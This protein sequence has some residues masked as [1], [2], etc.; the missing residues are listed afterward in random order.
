MFNPSRDQVRDL[1]FETW[2]KYRA[3]EPLAGVESLALAATL[4]HPEYH[5]ML[6]APERSRARDYLP[7]LGESNPFL[8]L[9]L[10]LAL[11]E[12]LSIDQPRGVAAAFARLL[13]RWLANQAARS[14][15]SC[16]ESGSAKP[17]MIALL[18]RPAL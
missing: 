2:R 6:D 18:R 9:S 4:L 5:T 3:G 7:E 16:L 8:H 17:F 10:H 14:R 12:Q 1:F 11:E 13:A 15:I